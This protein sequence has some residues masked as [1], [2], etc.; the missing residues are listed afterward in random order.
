MTPDPELLAAALAYAARGWPVIPVHEPR[1]GGGCTC[2]QQERCDRPGKHP[3]WARGLLEHGLKDASTDPERIHAWWRRWPHANIGL[4]TGIGFDV[5]DIDG[6]AGWAALDSWAAEHGVRL[7]GPAAQ[8]GSGG[9]HLLLAPTG[10]GNRTSLLPQVD[11]RGRDGFIVAPPSAHPSGRRYRWQRHPD[12]LALPAAPP[13]LHGLLAP[14][15]PAPATVVAARPVE[16]GHA[17]GRQALAEELAKLRAATPDV[18]RNHTL[19]RTAFRAYQLV[20]GGVLDERDVTRAFTQTAL[21]VGLSE[22]ETR[23]TLR[24]ARAGGFRFPR[25]VPARQP[26]GRRRDR[27]GGRQARERM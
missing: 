19:N 11:Y 12:G 14:T 1:A 3:R 26:S 7:V 15:R 2:P 27:T 22:R 5:L 24:S 6:P 10:A 4:R 21:A 20:A 23:A 13:A 18:D 25:G 16:R 8:T 17:Y 9:W